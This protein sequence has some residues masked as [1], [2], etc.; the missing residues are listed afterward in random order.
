M[1]SIMNPRFDSLRTKSKVAWTEQVKGAK[2][3]GGNGQSSCTQSVDGHATVTIKRLFLHRT[4]RSYA[5]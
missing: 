4:V 1:H 5:K 2:S 3:C